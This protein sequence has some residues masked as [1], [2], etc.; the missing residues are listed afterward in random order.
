[1]QTDLKSDNFCG[2]NQSAAEFF[3]TFMP[4]QYSN[5]YSIGEVGVPAG[6]GMAGSYVRPDV[7]DVSSFLSGRDDILS[8]C[9]PP[10]PSLDSLNEPPL[11]V[12][13]NI[14]MLVPKYT[15]E[16]RSTNALD[17]IDYNRYTP[18]LPVDPQDVRFVIEDMA[19]QRGGFNTR[20][21]VRSAWNN[22]N[23]VPNF[24]KNSCMTNLDPAMAFG[25]E[26]TKV[27]GYPGVNPL[28]GQRKSA[29]YMPAGKP[30]GQPDYPFTDITSQQIQS[31]GA[32]ACGPQFF[33]GPNYTIGSCPPSVP[34]MFKRA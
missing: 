34:Q 32:A 10:V 9:T 8:K 12:Q 14:D 29:I 28:T 30:P 21:Y 4:N 33:S 22:Q 5:T 15:K 13:G 2:Y 1:M 3:W 27:N 24:D 23:N 25:P 17:S 11:A 31:V 7:I 16:L 6:G 20:N 26:S 19:P 18:N